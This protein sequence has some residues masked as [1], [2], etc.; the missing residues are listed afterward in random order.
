LVVTPE[1]VELFRRGFE[2][3][4]AG[5]HESWEDEGGRRSEF[6]EISKRL[7]WT[8]L[9]RVGEVSVL[10]PLLGDEEMRP[11]PPMAS[12]GIGWDDGTKLRLALLH[13]IGE[14]LEA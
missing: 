4:K 1:M 6:L 5:T 12:G 10:D 3:Q 7:D 9:G 8:L 13:A 11:P 2:I 14:R